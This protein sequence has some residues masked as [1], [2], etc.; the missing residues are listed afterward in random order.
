LKREPLYAFLLAVI[1]FGYP[2]ISLVQGLQG[3]QIISSHGVVSYGTGYVYVQDGGFYKDGQEVKFFGVNYESLIRPD[4]WGSFWRVPSQD[5]FIKMREYGFNLIRLNINWKILEPVPSNYNNTYLSHIDDI[6]NWCEMNGIYVY[7]NIHFYRQDQV[8]PSWISTANEYSDMVNSSTIQR[9]V[10]VWSILAD[11]YKN[12]PYILGYDVPINEVEILTSQKSFSEE[13]DITNLW[14]RW[15]ERKFNGDLSALNSTWNWSVYDQL[16][17]EEDS[18]DDVLFPRTIRGYG[19][20]ESNFDAR[21][22][23]YTEFRWEWWYNLTERVVEAIKSKD[24]NHLCIAEVMGGG[25]QGVIDVSWIPQLRIP[26][27]VD[28]IDRHSYPSWGSTLGFERHTTVGLEGETVTEIARW[29]MIAEH[30]SIPFIVGEAGHMTPTKDY[31]GEWGGNWTGEICISA[32]KA[33]AKAILLYTWNREGAGAYGS[34]NQLTLIYDDMTFRDEFDWLPEFA[35]LFKQTTWYN[36]KAEVALI[37]LAFGVEWSMKG[38]LYCLNYL[39]VIPHVISQ[40]TL[41][42]NGTAVLDS[43]KLVICSPDRLSTEAI[44]FIKTWNQQSPSHKVLWIGYADRDGFIKPQSWTQ[45]KD[46]MLDSSYKN[47]YIGVRRDVVLKI[48]NGSFGNLTEGMELSFR[49]SCYFVNVTIDNI[50]DLS[51]YKARIMWGDDYSKVALWTINDTAAWFFCDVYS[52]GC[53]G[54]DHSDDYTLPPQESTL[55]VL[56]ATLDWAGIS[57]SYF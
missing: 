49:T 13:P 31:S 43:Y 52:H 20:G 51:G 47:D 48:V 28:G 45:W 50:N 36:P 44:S 17:A 5:E 38:W 27:G 32:Y 14:H 19:G 11:R 30:L 10:N 12:E 3:N 34:N 40:K 22:P 53:W 6:V 7:L 56:N 15:L 4:L 25:D 23:T 2:V 42:D 29:A 54:Y 35:R 16:S 57:R 24:S 21:R 37:D 39:H 26:S 33:G 18:F 9:L 41:L 55:A 46:W 8:A 1:L